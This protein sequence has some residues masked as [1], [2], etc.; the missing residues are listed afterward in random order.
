MITVNE[1]YPFSNCPDQPQPADDRIRCFV[2]VSAADMGLEEVLCARIE[3]FRQR[4][5]MQEIRWTPRDF[6]HLTLT[7]MGAQPRQVLAPL[8]LLLDESLRN[9]VAFPLVLTHCSGFPDA[10]SRIIA[11]IPECSPPLSVLQQSVARAVATVGIESDARPYL[12][13]ITLGRLERHRELPDFHEALQATGMVR[14]VSLYRSD[15]L[16]SGSHYTVI[17][18]W[19]LRDP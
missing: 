15:A 10:K 8:A 12:P 5:D 1:K 4:A 19:T 3:R 18:R 7:F 16:A 14:A 13:H 17:A 2:G 11:A 9:L 6:L